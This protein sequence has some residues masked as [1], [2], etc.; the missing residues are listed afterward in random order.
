[1]ITCTLNVNNKIKNIYNS[2]SCTHLVEYKNGHLL[3]LIYLEKVKIIE[4]D[5]NGDEIKTHPIFNGHLIPSYDH[6]VENEL[7]FTQHTNNTNLLAEY[8]E[9]IF[10][11]NIVTEES[12]KFSKISLNSDEVLRVKHI[13]KYNNYYVM[14]TETN[15]LKN[16]NAI[17]LKID[18]IVFNNE[19]KY[20]FRDRI[21]EI[22]GIENILL[23]DGIFYIKDNGTNYNK[24]QNEWAF[25]L[26]L[27]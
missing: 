9:D 23:E 3:P 16:G 10:K 5:E 17:D 2:S 18:Y 21:N 13:F 8:K 15:I 11:Y 12:K 22:I 25:E 20:L 27:K 4:L 26:K 1:M 7:Y 24:P 6:L 14:F 19:M